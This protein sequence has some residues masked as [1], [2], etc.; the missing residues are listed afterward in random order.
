[1]LKSAGIVIVRKVENTYRFLM[2]RSYDY[3]D[4]PKGRVEEG[5]LRELL[6]KIQ[7]LRKEKGLSIGDSAVLIATDD[8]KP[9]I[10]K[11]EEQIK[12]AT[13]LSAIEYGT[14]LKLK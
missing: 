7:D 10:S 4:F 11:H 12:K 3:W 13:G 6:R 8:L 9:L 2:L 14:E 1:M 5:E